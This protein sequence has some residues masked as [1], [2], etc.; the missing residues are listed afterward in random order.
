M[1][2]EPV[3][4]AAL[5]IAADRFSKVVVCNLLGSG[6]VV[7][8]GA[9]LRIRYVVTRFQRRGLLRSPTA[10]LLL[11]T[12]ALGVVLLATSSGHFFQHPVAQMG[13]GAALAGSGSNLY[14]RLRH[15]A[16]IDF[17]DLG[18]WPAS[19]LA[20]IAIVLGVIVSLRFL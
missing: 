20:D 17:L 13:L 14:D 16:V 10:L 8:I 15:G 6:R 1:L 19:N 5:V 9:R 7:P 11:W 3:L 12:A 18:W 2:I 4:L